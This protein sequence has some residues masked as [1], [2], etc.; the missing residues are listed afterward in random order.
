MIGGLKSDLPFCGRKNKTFSPKLV[1][2]NVIQIHINEIKG[3]FYKD[4]F[5]CFTFPFNSL[6]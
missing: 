6:L 3:I 2:R 5:I 4:L 1:Q